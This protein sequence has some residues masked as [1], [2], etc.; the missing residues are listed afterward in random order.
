MSALRSYH[1]DDGTFHKVFTAAGAR[2]EIEGWKAIARLLPAPRLLDVRDVADGTELVYDDVFATGRC[3][4]LLADTITAADVDS[5]QVGAV[6][7]L[8]NAMCDSWHASLKVTGTCP[9]LRATVP[10]LYTARL[11][12]GGRLERWY[13]GQPPFTVTTATTSRTIHPGMLL[14]ELRN[15][16]HPDSRWLSAIT[17]GDPTEPNIAEPLCWLD[18]EHAGLGALAGQIANALWY[19][20]AMGGW[21]VPAYQPATYART[22][23][24]R[25]NGPHPPHVNYL[26]HDGASI[27]IDYAFTARPG[28]RAALDALLARLDTDLG[29]RLQADLVEVLRPWLI[30]RV[31]GVIPLT[32][33]T[34]AD[35][36]VCWAAVADITAPDITLTGFTQTS[37][38]QGTIR[39][40]TERVRAVATTHDGR[41]VTIKRIKPGTEPYWVLPG[42]GI[43]PGDA[44]PEAALT[45]EL[46]EELG[47]TADIAAHIITIDRERCGAV[48]REHFYL[49]RLHSYDL[50]QRYGPEFTD[51]SRGEYLLD[52]IP[53]TTTDLAAI[54]LLPTRIADLL[55]AIVGAGKTL[56]EL[57]ELIAR[58]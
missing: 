48:D 38:D 43:E 33:M 16:L 32:R 46:A 41:L 29:T 7:T 1:A 9:P 23:T 34:P 40:M 6:E 4:R 13:A 45:R 30:L 14:A 22:L 50:S 18:F 20:L 54:T 53:L 25:G 36:A 42:G 26:R 5:A 8:V 10:A 37:D 55:A 58:Q 15:T 21:L 28:R 51:P 47:A 3:V 17:Q 52:L 19:L 12:P 57:P 27:E 49:V 2:Q 39:A 31:L 11:A 44:T 24:H 35:Q 56:S